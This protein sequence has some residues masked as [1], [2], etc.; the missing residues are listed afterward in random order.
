MQNAENLEDLN[1]KKT[2]YISDSDKL[3]IKDKKPTKK[4]IENKSFSSTKSIKLE[5]TFSKKE[6][7][8]GK[9]TENEYKIGHYIIKKT[10]GQGTFGKVKLGIYLPNNEK[11]AIKILEKSK[12]INIDDEIRIKREFEMLS[13]FS[14]PNVILVAEIFESVDKYYC[15]MEYCEGGELFNYI[16]KKKYL[17]ENEAAFYYFQLINGLEYIHSLGI[18]HR[19]IK[20]EN[21]LL[22]Q[23]HLLKII[24]F[25]LSNYYNEKNGKLLSSTC[26]S[27]C[28]AAPEMVSGKKYD[29]FKID[30]W[31]SGIVLYVMLCGK[32]P[33]LQKNDDN[34][35]LFQEII[36]CNIKYPNNLSK[37]AIDLLKKILVPV[38]N[39]RISI[40]NIKKHPFYLKGKRIFE[41]EFILVQLNDNYKYNYNNNDSNNENNNNEKESIKLI[42]DINENKLS[43]K[44]EFFMNT[45]NKNSQKNNNHITSLKKSS[46]MN[47]QKNINVKLTDKKSKELISST[48]Y[49]ETEPNQ[50]Q[51]LTKCFNN[52][53]LAL[54][55]IHNKLTKTNSKPTINKKSKYLNKETNSNI[56]QKNN[57]DEKDCASN[58]RLLTDICGESEKHHVNKVPKSRIF[59]SNNTLINLQSNL[60]SMQIKYSKGKTKKIINNKLL[61]NHNGF[62]LQN[63]L[64]KNK[65]H[66]KQNKSNINNYLQNFNFNRKNSISKKKS[67]SNNKTIKTS[68]SKLMEFENSFLPI[69]TEPDVDYKVKS[70]KK[71]KK[72]D[73]SPLNKILFK[74]R[75]I[76]TNPNINYNNFILRQRKINSTAHLNYNLP[77]KQILK[78]HSNNKNKNIKKLY[79]INSFINRFNIK[80]Y[81]RI[82]KKTFTNLLS[83]ELNNYHKKIINYRDQKIKQTSIQCYK[84][85]KKKKSCINKSSLNNKYCLSNRVGLKDKKH[86]KF[87]SVKLEEDFYGINKKVLRQKTNSKTK[88]DKI[89]YKMENTPKCLISSNKNI[90]SNRNICQ[91]VKNSI[92]HIEKNGK[93]YNGVINKY[94]SIKN[95]NSKNKINTMTAKNFLSLK[96]NK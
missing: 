54:S 46:L 77:I 33:F 25:G 45:N 44:S 60:I 48:K 80:D 14:H 23:D 1:E 51:Y 91:T 9:L 85:Y 15:V 82:K 79:T 43:E 69:K 64:I 62:Y 83:G 21:L 68:I 28:Y 93:N 55:N 20:P 31:S 57:N 71:H 67:N 34:D 89:L 6:N 32:L 75:Y 8:T 41:K 7:S 49:I 78:T 17:N 50:T 66:I 39:E 74:N 24:D 61:N 18:T 19:D 63:I 94:Y 12:I 58:K 88:S 84:L 92:N 81:I 13:K 3:I 22:T 76:N 42:T 40:S 72:L 86:G 16:T 47:N 35:I 53:S 29:G 30:I 10:L 95:M 56:K 70:L 11:V 87:N 38:P 73:T 96:I 37:K 2:S 27:P 59:N 26:G 52:Q 65:S 36:K 5:K 90:K 4:N